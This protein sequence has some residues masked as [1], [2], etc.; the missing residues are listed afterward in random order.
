[1]LC[2]LAAAPA[3]AAF[4][5]APIELGPGDGNSPSVVVDASGTAHVAWGIA[6]E[7]I[8][9]CAL[10]PGARACTRSARL[11]LDARAGRPVLMQ[12]PQDGLLVLVAGRDEAREDPDESV[13]AFTSADGATWSPPA[14]IGLGLGAIDAAVLTADGQA[15][16][17]LEAGG[18]G[19]LF[20]RAPLAG[21]PAAAVLDLSST[22][23][24]ASTRFNFPGDMVRTA[25]GGTLA[26]LGS[27]ADGFAFR[28]LRA[29]DPLADASWRPWP[30]RRVTREWDEPRAAAGPRGAYVMYGSGILDQ[31][32]GAAPQL[33]RKLRKGRFGRPRGLF[34]E[35]AGVTSD[36]ALAQDARGRLHAAMVGDANPGDRTC[37]AYARTSGRRWFTRAVSLHQTVT[38]AA[39]PGRLRLAVAPSGRGVVAWATRGTPSVARVQRLKAGR[40]VTRPLRHA[41]RGCPRFPR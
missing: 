22:P 34:Y 13:W 1:M 39:E 28:M 16:D 4:K 20:Q 2:V 29:G 8:G 23:A 37:I 6:E 24:G 38:A 35:V 19:N 36:A 40:G 26:F 10:P 9:Y 41:R 11:A 14:P 30:A 15:V 5:R 27:P 25:G 17:L 32:G 18:D 33:V 3:P 7:L 21:P 12:R 31:V